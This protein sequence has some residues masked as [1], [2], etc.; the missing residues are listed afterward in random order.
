MAFFGVNFT[1][2]KFC[3]CK[4]NDKYQVWG[5]GAL[6]IDKANLPRKAISTKNTSVLSFDNVCGL[7]ASEYVAKPFCSPSACLTWKVGKDVNWNRDKGFDA[8]FQMHSPPHFLQKKTK[9][10]WIF[11]DIGMKEAIQ[12]YLTTPEKIFS[13]VICVR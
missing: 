2:Q 13:I 5:I 12:E 1:L 4:K 6:I 10:H 9:R 11:R 8:A 3:Q 7:S